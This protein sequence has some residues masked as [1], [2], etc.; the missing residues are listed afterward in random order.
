MRCKHRDVKFIN[1]CKV[2]I[3]LFTHPPFYLPYILANLKWSSVSSVRRLGWKRMASRLRKATLTKL[4]KQTAG[5]DAQ[6]LSVLSTYQRYQLTHE[7]FLW[8]EIIKDT[9]SVSSILRNSK[10][11]FAFNYVYFLKSLGELSHHTH[12]SPTLVFKE[13]KKKSIK[14][15]QFTSKN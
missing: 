8:E 10:L 6:A 12:K 2:S 4:F 3:Y 13:K 1:R 11:N 9:R 5:Q 15:L 14:G 7:E